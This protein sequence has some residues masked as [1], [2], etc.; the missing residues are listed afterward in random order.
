MALNAGCLVLYIQ[1]EPTTA[2]D[3]I[4]NNALFAAD[5]NTKDFRTAREQISA[6]R[7][8]TVATLRECG[9]SAVL[10]EALV[11][12]NYATAVRARKAAKP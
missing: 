11:K 4:K 2:L 3:I 9:V 10:A 7:R 1:G 5:R 8:N 12:A 6:Y